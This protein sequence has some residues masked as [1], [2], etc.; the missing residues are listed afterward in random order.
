MDI[1][2]ARFVPYAPS[3]INALAFSHTQ[4]DDLAPTTQDPTGLRLALGRANGNIEI[5][6]PSGGAWVQERVFPGGKERSVEGLVWTQ[7]P[8]EWVNEPGGGKKRVEGRLRLFSI[9]YSNSVT[10]WDLVSG[11]PARQS[12]GNSSEVWCFAA[13][14]R[15]ATSR[16]SNKKDAIEGGDEHQQLAAGCA[17]GTVVLL[18]TADNDVRFERFLSRSTT[19]KAR[20]L[21]IAFKDRNVVLAGYADSTIR[22]LDTRNASVLR[23]ISLGSGPIGGPKDILVWKVKCFPNGDFVSGDSTGEIRIYDGKNYSQKQRIAG[24]EADILDLAVSQDGTMI[25]SGG[26]DRRTCC[27]TCSKKK[28]NKVGQ[29]AKVSH[30]RHHEH[31]VKAMA[32]YEGHQL[33]VLVSG[34]IDTKPIVL[35]IRQFGKEYS[36]SLP[37]LPHTPPLASAREARLLVSWWNCEVRIWRVKSKQGGSEKP[38]VVARIA[39]QG[40]ENITSASISRDGSLLAVSTAAE[41]KLFHVAPSTSSGGPGLRIRKLEMPTS[42]GAKLVRIAPNG[43]WIGV[44]TVADEIRFVRVI[45]AEETSERPRVLREPLHVHRLRRDTDS[46]DPLNGPWGQYNRSICHAE[47]SSTSSFFAV[48]DLAGYVDTFVVEGYEDATAPEL[49]IAK[50]SSTPSTDSEES[51]DEHE[52]PI[53]RI[54][55]LGQRWIRNP[56]AHLLP[57]LNSTP[58]FLSFKPIPEDAARPEP[59]GNPAVHPTRHNPHPRPR[60]NPETEEPL[61][62]VSAKHE[63]YEFEPLAGRLS[64]WC[65][66]NPPSSYPAQFQRLKEPVKGCIWDVSHENRRLWL[67]GENFLFMFDLSQDLPLSR[68]GDASMNGAV[69]VAPG[70]KKRKR[71]ALT[72]S[73]HQTPRRGHAGAGDVVRSRQAPVS[74]I[75]KFES[76]GGKGEGSAGGRSTW[77]DV[78]ALD[79]TAE[80]DDDGEEED[81]D[82]RQARRLTLASLRGREVNGVE[83]AAEDGEG[84]EEEEGRKREKDAWWHTLKYRPILGIVP[85]GRDDEPLEVVLVERPS[86]ELDLPPRFVGAHE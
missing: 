4:P 8:D 2:R 13:Q 25:F 70:A 60:Y 62:V 27:Y 83:T 42:T 79:R 53:A 43:K 40:Q 28:G 23:T 35:P 71:D 30:Q 22:V 51:D 59:N 19:K 49:D 39:L 57:R 7:E 74:K 18:S 58:L 29:W 72:E 86:W 56:S 50:P 15:R 69:D 12:S 82:D 5:W 45:P 68:G 33:N 36:R 77:I 21:S 32:T 34:G 81:E 61:L 26:M 44:V 63:L 16:G 38:K 1:H 37:F 48:A 85:V 10:E 41:V 46:R 75:R 64:D 78:G 20:V 31:D 9:G 24:H 55:S 66:R 3:A 65:R 17:D 11:L 67:Y 54:T 76:G 84:D 80:S 47:F 52:E 73:T 14:P 6:N